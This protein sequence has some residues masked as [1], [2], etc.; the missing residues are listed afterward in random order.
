[1]LSITDLSVRLAGRLL[2]DQSSVQIAPGSRVG[3]VGRNGTGKSTLFKV[4]RGELAAESGSVTLPPRWRVGS[5]AQ[6]APDGPESLIAVVLKADLERDALLREAET[7]HDPHRIAE[8]QTRL[9]DIDAHSAPSR[10]AAILSGL[11]FS[12][13]DQARPCSEFSGGWR[14]RVALAATL[15]A[16]PD[17]L[18]LDEPTNYLDLEGT[19]WLE[20]HLAHYPRTVIVV[21]HDRDLLESSVDQILHLERGK[22]T[23]YRGTY[24]SFE[25]QRAAREVLDAKQVKRQEAER[26][27]LQAFVDRFKAKASKARQAQSRVKMLERLKPITALVTD[28]VHEISFPPP[29]KTLS[30]PIIAVDNA[31][32]GYDAASPVLSR[33]T[34]RIDD[35][36][37]I[38]LLGA[39]GNGKST[40][41]KLLAGRLAPFSGR[42]TRADKLSIAYFA[43]HQLDELNVDASAYDHVR[44]LMGEAPESKIRARAGA[45]GFSGKA[46][47]TPAGKLSG[48][49]KARL[50]LGL[51]TFFGPNMIILDEPTN[52]LDIDSR[53]ALAE[54]INDFPGAVIMVS[55]DRYLIEACAERLW[56]V[57]DRTVTNYDGDLDDY[58]RVVLSARGMEASPRERSNG[59]DKPQR[60][61]MDGRGPLKKRIAEAES[62]IA[63][64]TEIIAK[65]DTALSLPDIFTRDPKQAAQLSKARANAADALTRAE[66][67]WLEASAQFD[68][69]ASTA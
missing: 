43:Q 33:V 66:E 16:A 17:L 32:V 34:L 47:D 10:A 4:I 11:G 38:A 22:L 46:A 7:A 27:R 54:A 41:V 57:A 28:E 50:L 26:A 68:E 42:V 59:G 25:E 35:D 5:L 55:H 49:E 30:P 15:F 40:L 6:E 29:E 53:A 9:V 2:I 12:A 14:M 21:S 8:I 18:L 24:S 69:A 64:I 36:D 62:E 48:G 13:S 1:M 23:L 61:K 67:Q 56:L 65:I 63:R 52:H 45:I 51:A 58:R 44:K 60:N 39:N 3:L 20:D 37:R 31:T 19:L